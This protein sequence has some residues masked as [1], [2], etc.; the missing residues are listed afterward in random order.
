[1]FEKYFEIPYKNK[2]SDFV[3]GLILEYIEMRVG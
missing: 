3:V 2:V 1:M